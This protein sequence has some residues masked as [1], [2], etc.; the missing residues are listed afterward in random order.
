[1]TTS[2]CFSHQEPTSRLCRPITPP[3][4]TPA[5]PYQPR[6]L[7]DRLRRADKLGDYICALPAWPVEHPLAA[8]LGTRLLTAQRHVRTELVRQRQALRP[9]A[10]D[11]HLAGAISF[12]RAVA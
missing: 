7:F 4:I 3:Q 6:P 10:Q 2:A 5:G 1:M 8:F 11:D 9:A 12:A